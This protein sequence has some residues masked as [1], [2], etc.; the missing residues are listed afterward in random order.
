MTQQS[1]SSSSLP[2]SSALS[3]P[4]NLDP[5]HDIVHDLVHDDDELAL[6][7]RIVCLPQTFLC[8]GWP[9]ECRGLPQSGPAQAAPLCAQPH[10][11]PA[12][13]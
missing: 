6:V 11:P 12:L 3:P 4:C 10:L 2:S 7:R 1:S 13:W 8:N 9:W 5:D